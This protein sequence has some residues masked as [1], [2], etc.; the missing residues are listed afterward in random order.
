MNG[1]PRISVFT[2]THHPRFLDE[3]FDSLL[4]QTYE[5]WEWVVLLNSGARWRPA[6]SDPRL[7]IVIDDSISGVGAAK[8]RACAEAGGAVL[9]ELDHDDIL[10]SDALAEITRAFDENPA[11]SLVYSHTAQILEDGSRD[12]SRFDIS[13]GWVYHD[14]TVDGREVQYVEAMAPTPHNVSYIW[15]APNHV[16]AYD[17]AAYERVERL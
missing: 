1:A 4:A 6:R 15:F 11:A 13:N 3:C 14:T 7:R 16:R 2:V 17:R 9:V 8:H 5:D 10:A 12:D